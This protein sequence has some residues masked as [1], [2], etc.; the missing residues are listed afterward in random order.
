MTSDA[1][2]TNRANIN[3]PYEKGTDAI[4]GIATGMGQ[5]PPSARIL[6]FSLG[7]LIAMITL[8]ACMRL[9]SAKFEEIF[10]MDVAIMIFGVLVLVL[11]MGYDYTLQRMSLDQQQNKKLHDDAFNNLHKSPPTAAD[12]CVPQ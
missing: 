9:G 5:Q 12:P 2:S 8:T 10:R 11:Y 1:K 4:K 7:L 3:F 6:V